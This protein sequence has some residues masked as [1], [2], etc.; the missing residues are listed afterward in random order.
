MP[1]TANSAGGNSPRRL[2]D[3]RLLRWSL[4]ICCLSGCALALT[5]CVNTLALSSKVLFG[6]P[7]QVSAFQLATGKSLVKSDK[8]VLVYCAAEGRLSD[9][10]GG[11][12]SDV[13]ERLIQRMKKQHIAALPPD[14]GAN[15]IDRVGR[16][17]PHLLA[18]ELPE[19]DYIMHIQLDGFS[20][21]QP[22]SP[23]LYHSRAH[24]SIS[25]YEVRTDPQGNRYITQV[26]GQN[27]VAEYPQNQPIP[28]EQISSSVFYRRAVEHLADTI[29]G[30]F[31]DVPLAQLYAR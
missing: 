19:V 14:T 10:F 31:Y 16:F 12:S 24:G 1:R 25:G 3:W 22:G 26:L 11:L 17:D 15:I 30:S 5:G 2:T 21:T 4:L 7:K 23:S 6:D 13:Q 20:V 8:K 9:E 29:G 27:F 28:R 18:A